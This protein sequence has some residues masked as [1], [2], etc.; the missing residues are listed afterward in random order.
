MV[1][2]IKV[3]AVLVRVLKTARSYLGELART[4]EA[5][6]EFEGIRFRCILL[7]I[8]LGRIITREGLSVEKQSFVIAVPPIGFD[9]KRVGGIDSP[10]M[11]S[12]NL[13]SCQRMPGA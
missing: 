11:M 4:Q 6:C 1:Y 8:C 10:L 7:P 2:T 9:W 5:A 12:M 13:R 3:L